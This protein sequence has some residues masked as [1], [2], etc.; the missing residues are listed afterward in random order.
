[1]YTEVYYS[2]NFSIPCVLPSKTSSNKLLCSVFYSY[3]FAVLSN[4]TITVTSVSHFLIDHLD[5][6][7][8]HNNQLIN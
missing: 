7:V 3:I 6:H 5:Y 1:M 8:Y 4:N 2:I